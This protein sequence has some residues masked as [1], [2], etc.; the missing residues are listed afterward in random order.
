[1]NKKRN[2]VVSLTAAAM[3]AALVYGVYELQLRQIDLQETV[4]VVVPVRFISAGERLTEKDLGWKTVAKAS[5]E[6][7]MLRSL[8]QA[9]GLET[10]IPIGEGEPI[11][12]WKLD[13]FRLLP[14]RD[15]ST[16]QIPKAYVLSISSGIRAGDRVLLYV[17]GEGTVS[18]RLFDA[19][20]TVASVKTSANLEI[21]DPQN[22]NLLSMASGNRE[23]MYASR[24]DAN[25]TI[26]AVNLNL[27]EEQWLRIDGLCK[28]GKARLVV[29]FSSESPISERTEMNRS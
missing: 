2:L 12:D 19:P 23:R 4:R 11:L 1:M 28:N 26:D 3:A 21:D 8:D 16:F 9:A 27:T 14:K 15:E 22:S 20:I 24:R 29:A 13:R 17:S 6:P 25:G 18:A 10:A 7:G 5:V